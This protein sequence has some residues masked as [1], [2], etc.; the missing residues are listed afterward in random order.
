MRDFVYCAVLFFSNKLVVRRLFNDAVSSALLT[1]EVSGFSRML[2]WKG[3]RKIVA[4][5][6]RH[7][8]GRT[9]ENHENFQSRQPVT[10]QKN[11]EGRAL[12]CTCNF[13]SHH[14]FW[15][16]YHLYQYDDMWRKNLE[17]CISTD[18]E[19]HAKLAKDNY[20]C[21]LQPQHRI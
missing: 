3:Q 19:K 10:G 9:E 15:L 13:G 21:K 16:D 8:P 12:M 6:F 5:S 17:F 11:A 18:L 4:T 2:K 7:P 20:S 1:N 14:M